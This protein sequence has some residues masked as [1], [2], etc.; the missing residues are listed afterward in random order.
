MRK[1]KLRKLITELET[2][3]EYEQAKQIR[4][5]CRGN[6]RKVANLAKWW[7]IWNPR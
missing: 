1:M 4:E 5:T 6:K 2:G 3:G 7:G